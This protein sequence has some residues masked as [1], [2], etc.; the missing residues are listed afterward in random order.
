[1]VGGGNEERMILSDQQREENFQEY[2]RLRQDP[3][4]YD[5]TFDDKSG[6]VSAIHREHKFDSEVGAYGIKIGEYERNAIDALRRQGHLVILESEKVPNGVK[7]P[8]GSLDGL[9]MEIKSVEKHGKWAVKSKLHQAAKQGATCIVLYFHKK[10]LFSISRIDF[11]WNS[12]LNDDSSLQYNSRISRVIC[13]VEDKVI[14][15]R[16][17]Q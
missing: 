2:L 6:G 10:E 8:D 14:P 12:Y 3:N 17:P 4:Y 11:G 5:V 1:M 16:I 7:T 13:I 15:Y 9:V